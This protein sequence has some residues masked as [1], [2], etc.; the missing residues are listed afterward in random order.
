MSRGNV[1]YDPSR[2]ERVTHLVF[3][4]TYDH[5]IDP[6]N[7]LAI[8][9]EVRAQIKR[10][11]RLAGVSDGDG[12]HGGDRS[13]DGDKSGGK[14]GGKG[15]GTYLYVTLAKG[16]TLCLYTEQGYGKRAGELDHSEM[17]PDELMEYERIFYS[18]SKLVE[19][20]KQGRLTLPGDLLSR[21]GLGT[22]VVLIGVKDHM[23]VRD[24]KAWYEHLE[25]VLKDR[26][27]MLMNPRLAMRKRENKG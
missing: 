25:R 11:A 9:S 7:R 5:T 17:D 22:D 8:P 13:G 16:G 26:P 2:P 19:L 4:G 1:S 10:A 18:S 27:D 3:T 14:S 21:S 6:K 12:G 20:D 24:R 15:D 23:E